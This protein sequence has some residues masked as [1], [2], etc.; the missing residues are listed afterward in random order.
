MRLTRI[1]TPG[2]L[3]ESSEVV[4]TPSGANHVARVLR[5]RQGDVIGVFN[6]DGRECRATI[7]D[8]TS[9]RVAVRIDTLL[10]TAAE[11]PLRITLLQGVSRGERMDFVVQKATELGVQAIV[12]VVTARSVV[13]IG[14][15]QAAK[16]LEHWR[17]IAI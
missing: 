9:R 16:K 10:P 12:P 2:P 6:G 5:L 17:N 13:R 11:S 15:S 1:Y 3:L 4:L 8:I 14:T 7:A